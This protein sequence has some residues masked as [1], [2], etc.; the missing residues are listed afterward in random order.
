[1]KPLSRC[2]NV[3]FGWSAGKRVVVGGEVGVVVLVDQNLVVE[4]RRPPAHRFD[5]FGTHEIRTCGSSRLPGIWAR[6]SATSS[7]RTGLVRSWIG[8]RSRSMKRSRSI[9]TAAKRRR[10]G[11]PCSSGRLG[12]SRLDDRSADL[13]PSLDDCPVLGRTLDGIDRSTETQ[14]Q[15]LDATMS[16]IVRDGID[17][18]SLRDV[19]READVSLGLLSYHFDD[20]RALIVAAFGLRTIGC[21]RRASARSTASTGPTIGSGPSSAGR[22]TASSSRAG[23]PRAPCGALGD[24]TYRR[25]DRDSSRSATTTRYL[26]TMAR[27]IARSPARPRP[28]RRRGHRAAVDVTA[29]QNGLWLNWARYARSSGPRSGARSCDRIALAPVDATRRQRTVT[30]RPTKPEKWADPSNKLFPHQVGFTAPPMDFDAAPTDFLRICPPS[31]GV[32]GRLLARTRYA[33][34]LS[35]RAGQLP[36]ARRGRALH[37]QRGADVVG[38]VGTNWVH[39]NGTDVHDIRRFVAEL[40]E[41]YETP[42]H[43]AGLTLVDAVPGARLRAVALNSVYFWPDWRDGVV[44]FLRSADIDVIWYGNFVDQGFYDTQ[45]EVNDLTWIFPGDLAGEVD[46]I[47]GRAGARR[48]RDTWSTGCRTT[49]ATTGC[50]AAS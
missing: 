13:E 1:M 34:E 6:V 3:R 45:A 11:S 49:A 42:F 26:D 20:R 22:S 33:H 7:R 35:Q 50:H 8:Y 40:S 48:R 4:R 31:V 15:I 14:E 29:L 9:S 10:H 41:R 30:N 19:A 36:P 43:M 16:C 17:G 24:L 23:V 28:T 38:Q 21:S 46:A 27:L 32:H 25:P 2:W 47:R 44:R 5:R 18:T 12:R 37:E 39:A